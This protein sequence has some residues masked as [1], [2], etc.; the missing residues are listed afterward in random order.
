MTLSGKK[1][2]PDTNTLAEFVEGK[3]LGRQY[4]EIGEHIAGC[5]ECRD[6]CRYAAKTN[7]KAGKG[8]KLSSG[9]RSRILNQ[10]KEM[11]KEEYSKDKQASWNVFV[12]RITNIFTRIEQSEVIAASE[13]NSTINFTSNTE[14]E[15]YKWK[16][17]LF[18]PNQQT[19][20]LKLRL[21]TPKNVNGTLVFCGNRL[22]VVKGE[23]SIGYE[24]LKKSFRNPE[25]AFIFEDG[26]KINGYPELIG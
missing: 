20:M 1:Q 8:A 19:D 12:N 22:E 9:I 2:C 10:I 6:L 13:I 14:D 15:N 3:L 23:T 4:A 18:I 5:S 26:K 11:Q 16:L 17:Q 24:L 7:A 25:V 21:E